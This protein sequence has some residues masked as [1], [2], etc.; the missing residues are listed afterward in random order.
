MPQTRGSKVAVI[1][2]EHQFS[3]GLTGFA[4]GG[5]RLCLWTVD[6]GGGVFF[7]VLAVRNISLSS[8]WFSAG[9]SL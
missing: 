8:E 1:L 6:K 5:E 7:P 3:G 9:L 2:V 4:A